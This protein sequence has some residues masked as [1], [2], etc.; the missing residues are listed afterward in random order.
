MSGIGN[1]VAY[2]LSRIK[3]EEVNIIDYGEISK[4]QE[5]DVELKTLLSSQTSLQFKKY[6]IS[7]CRFMWC[8]VST[9]LWSY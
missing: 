8:N 4:T 9:E 6:P 1:L 3:V 7:G 2:H 5:K